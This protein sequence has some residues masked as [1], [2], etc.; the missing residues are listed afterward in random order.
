M[1]RGI[2]GLAM[3]ALAAGMIGMGNVAPAYGHQPTPRFR[4]DGPQ[5]DGLGRKV[6]PKQHPE[7]GQR[8][9]SQAWREYAARVVATHSDR[10]D[11]RADKYLHSYARSMRAFK[12]ARGMVA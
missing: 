11:P 12:Q 5:Y 9:R 1:R 4:L 10:P 8:K 6:K 7:H 2:A 3:S